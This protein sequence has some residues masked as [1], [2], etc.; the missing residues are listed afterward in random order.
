MKNIAYRLNQLQSRLRS[1][2]N[3]YR[4]PPGS[5]NLL[6]VSKTWPVESIEQAYQAGQRAFGEN[7][8]QEAE[9]KISALSSR[10]I[11]WHFI[12]PVQ[13]NKTR[14]IAG[15]FHW[16]HS[17]DRLKTARRLSAAADKNHPLNI[18]VQINISGESSKSG[19]DEKDAATL[20]E[21]IMELPGLKLRGLMTM[22]APADKLEEQRQPFRRLR[23]LLESLNATG[24]SLDTLSMGT[25]HDIE[26]AVAEGATIIRVGTAIF[27]PRGG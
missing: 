21:Q 15:Q 25:S 6:A 10:D 23:R 22:P 19:I 9:N 20:C 18:C 26:A 13:S 27:G 11:E 3:Q 4:R 1:L 16:C 17:V 8:L 2:E 14:A 7:Y 24:L 12:G 5:V